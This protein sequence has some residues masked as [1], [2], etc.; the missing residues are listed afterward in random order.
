MRRDKPSPQTT[1]WMKLTNILTKRSCTKQ[2]I[3]CDS[4][5]IIYKDWPSQSTGIEIRIV[6]I[7]GQGRM[8]WPGGAE[9]GF[10]SASYMNAFSL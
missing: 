10:L 3:L 5:H 9:R 8:E 1:V 4:I 7:L 2:H 6:V